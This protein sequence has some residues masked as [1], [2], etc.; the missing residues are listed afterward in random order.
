[1]A[2][3]DLSFDMPRHIVDAFQIGDGGSA[4]FHHD[5]RH[6]LTVR[7]LEPVAD[8][9][10]RLS[11][12]GKRKQNL[13]QA[14]PETLRLSSRFPPREMQLAAFSQFIIAAQSPF[15]VL[16]AIKPAIAASCQAFHEDRLRIKGL[17]PENRFPLFGHPEVSGRMPYPKTGSHFSDILT[18]LAGCLIRKPVPTFRTS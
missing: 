13:K 11:Q 17:R 1:M 8:S 5:A 14:R 10:N 2:G 6:D 7:P 3:I 15:R 4:E 12:N 16:P 18:F 9:R